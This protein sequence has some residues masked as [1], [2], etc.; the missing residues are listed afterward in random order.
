MVSQSPGRDDISVEIK[1]HMLAK[2]P[3]GAT[4]KIALVMFECGISVGDS[5]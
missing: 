5:W 3:S 2:S 1:I 4:L